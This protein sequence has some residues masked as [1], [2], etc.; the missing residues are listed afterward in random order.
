M[1]R[2]TLHDPVCHS[3]RDK[4]FLLTTNELPDEEAKAAYL[5]LSECPNCRRALA[6]HVKLVGALFGT[7]GAAHRTA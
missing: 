3:I 4:M 5:H 6:E 1:S 2:R 7:M